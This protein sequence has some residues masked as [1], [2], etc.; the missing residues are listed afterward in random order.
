MER[1]H[2]SFKAEC[3]RNGKRRV[4]SYGSSVNVRIYFSFFSSIRVLIPRFSRIVIA[5]SGKSILWYVV[6]ESLIHP[7]PTVNQLQHY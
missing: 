4:F 6:H 2:G 3:L 1:L 7:I 5:G